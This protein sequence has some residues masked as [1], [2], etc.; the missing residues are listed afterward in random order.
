MNHY[1]NFDPYLIRQRNQEALREVHALRLQER[2]RKGRCP[3]GL[4]FV[5]LTRR[6]VEPLLRG[7]GLVS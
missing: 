7:V 2:L 3:R 4:W 5:A 6:G 1:M